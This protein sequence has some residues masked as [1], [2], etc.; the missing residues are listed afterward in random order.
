MFYVSLIVA[1]RSNQLWAESGSKTSSVELPDFGAM[2]IQTS[3]Y[4]CAELSGMAWAANLDF[5]TIRMYC[6]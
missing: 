3:R 2:W 1:R 6:F 4:T 5:L